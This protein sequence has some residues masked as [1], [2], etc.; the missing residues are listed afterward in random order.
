VTEAAKAADEAV[1]AVTEAVKQRLKQAKTAAEAAEAVTN[2]TTKR[3]RGNATVP[4][5]FCVWRPEWICV[6]LFSIRMVSP[7]QILDWAWRQK[8]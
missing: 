2:A 4:P 7:W 8:Q 6:I 3:R 1:E 5:A